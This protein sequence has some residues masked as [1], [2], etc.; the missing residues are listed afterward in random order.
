[1]TEQFVN[2]GLLNGKYVRWYRDLFSLHKKIVHGDITDIKGMELDEWQ[3]RADE[4]IRVMAVLI[5]KIIEK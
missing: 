1:L 2:K 5:E 4:F 3:A